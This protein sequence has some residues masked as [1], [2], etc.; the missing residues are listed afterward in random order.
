MC[1]QRPGTSNSEGGSSLVQCGAANQILSRRFRNDLHWFCGFLLHSL[2]AVS[3]GRILDVSL[4]DI[5][6]A[7]PRSYMEI[8]TSA[9]R[10][11]CLIFSKA[12]TPAIT[13]HWQMVGWAL[14]QWLRRWHNVQPL[15]CRVSLSGYFCQRSRVTGNGIWRRKSALYIPRI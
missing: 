5:I 12:N 8:A 1:N 7:F 3:G 11:M 6:A 2:W 14:G 13:N 15:F 9:L 10:G 4:G